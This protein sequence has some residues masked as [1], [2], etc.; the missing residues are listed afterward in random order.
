[1]L[2]EASLATQHILAACDIVEHEHK[3][4]TYSNVAR[5]LARETGYNYP[6]LLIEELIRDRA[7]YQYNSAIHRYE[8]KELIA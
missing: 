4:I 6:T 8:R 1:M 5:F 3:D 7:L 2:I